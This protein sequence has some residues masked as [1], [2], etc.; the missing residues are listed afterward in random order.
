MSHAILP[1]QASDLQELTALQFLAFAPDPSHGIFYPGLPS[2]S[3]VQARAAEKLLKQWRSTEGMRIVKCVE[4]RTS[5][6]SEGMREEGERDERIV[7]FAYLVVHA[8]ERTEAEWR[9]PPVVDSCS[10]EGR[11]DV[12]AQKIKVA[13]ASMRWRL[14][15]GQPHVAV[16]IIAVL[17]SCQRRGI[18]AQLVEWCVSVCEATG[19]PGYLTASPSGIGLY[20]RFGFRRVGEVV[21]KA[22]EWGGGEN[23]VS[24]GM[25]HG[26][27][28]G[29]R[30][31]EREEG[32][33]GV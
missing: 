18:G 3:R 17:P 14:W 31:V 10:T 20:T 26:R 6:P 21:V 30:E 29:E 28:P 9:V 2:D 16:G 25:V 27:A 19:L 32:V 4:R 23:L 33:I 24:V 7:G 15:A 22:E 5:F 1:A 11:Q 8:T 13:F 12:A